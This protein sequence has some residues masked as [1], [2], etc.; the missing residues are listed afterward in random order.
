M[1]HKEDYSSE[2]DIY[3]SDILDRLREK[4]G[5]ASVNRMTSVVRFYHLKYTYGQWMMRGGKRSEMR[6]KAFVE[7]PNSEIEDC[8]KNKTL[9]TKIKELL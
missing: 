7:I 3:L 2:F 9:P 1:T 8:M 5:Y 4:Y 6:Q